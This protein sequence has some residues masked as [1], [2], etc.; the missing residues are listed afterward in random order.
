MSERKELGK[1]QKVVCGFGGYQDA[2]IGIG[3]VLGGDSWGV[4]TEFDGAWTSDPDENSNWTEKSRALHLGDVF[5]M[6]RDTLRDAKVKDVT[7]LVGIPIEAT[8]DGNMLKSWR[9]LKEV[10]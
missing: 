5:L 1:I 3:F 6:L 2:Q 7:E 8:F 10:L 9:V 4:N